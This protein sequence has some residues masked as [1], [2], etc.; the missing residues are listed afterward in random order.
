MK[1]LTIFLSG[2]AILIATGISIGASPLQAQIGAWTVTP[3]MNSARSSASSVLLQDGRILVTGGNDS[4]GPTSSAEFFA[5]Q[6]SYSLA[7]PMNVPRSGHVAVVLQDGRVLVAGGTTNGGEATN[8]AEIFDPIANTWTNVTSGMIEARSGHSAALLHDGRVLIAGGANGTQI[9]S[10][11]EVFDP[12]LGVFT[13]SGVMASP[14]TQYAMTV[15]HDGRALIVGGNNG[16]APVASTDIFDPVAGTVSPGPVLSVA[17]F[18]HSAT[19]LLNGQVAV[20]GGNNGNADPAQMDVTPSELFDPAAAPAFITLATNLATPREGH[21]AFLLPN[22]NSVL[23][24]GGSTGGSSGNAAL[25]SAELFTPQQS[26]QGIWTY[27]FGSTGS[28]SVGRIGATGTAN[29]V[30]SPAS[31]MQAN[32][33]LLVAGG[34]DASGSP[35]NSSEVYGFATIQTDQGDYAPGTNVAIMGSGWQPGETVTLQLVESPLVDPQASYSVIADANGNISNSSFTTDSHDINVKFTLSAIGSVSRA[36]TTFTDSSAGSVT[37]N[38]TNSVASGYGKSSISLPMIVTPGG[39]NTVA[40]ATIWVDE[41]SGAVGT[42][43][44]IMR[45]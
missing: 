29:Q 16:I 42:T 41:G 30:S 38:N 8:S 17:R 33:V 24:V 3:P 25:A 15:L 2:A 21:L 28:M 23:I 6:V 11:L 4:N 27:L 7:S 20:I 5:A 12:N 26:P 39:A 1:R 35:L 9:S 45:Q 22:N 44:T 36:Q 18:G 40:F 13:A 19:T 32:G 31:V 10:T 43:I 37:F 34:A 14:R